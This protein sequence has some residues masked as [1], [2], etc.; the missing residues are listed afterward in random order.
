[1]QKIASARDVKVQIKGN[2]GLVE[3]DFK[4]EN[5]QRLRRFVSYY[6]V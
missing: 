1:L 3:R 6:A 4:P 5:F 2:N